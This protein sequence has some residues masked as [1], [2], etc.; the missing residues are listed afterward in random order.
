M[1]IS[2]YLTTVRADVSMFVFVLLRCVESV[3]LDRYSSQDSEGLK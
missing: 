1:S 2:L 3:S